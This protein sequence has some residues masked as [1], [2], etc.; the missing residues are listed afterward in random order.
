MKTIKIK[1]V[2]FYGAFNPEDNTITN[3]LRERYNVI[4]ADDPDYLFYSNFNKEYIKYDCVRIFYTGECLVPDFN[5]CD[6]A[7]A[8]EYLDFGDRYLRVPLYELFH[9]RNKYKKLLDNNVEK[10]NKTDFCGFVVSNDSGM[11]ERKQ[12]FEL[13]SAYKKV[14]SGGRYMNNI[15]GPVADKLAFDQ[16]HRFSLTFENC[17][18]E[19]YT[20][21]KIVE[22]FAAGVIPIY[23]GNPLIGREFNTKAFV[24]V[25][26]FS[27]LEDVVEYVKKID[28]DPKLYEQIKSEPI[29]TGAR[30]DLIDLRKFLF[31]I[32]DQPLESARRRPRNTYVDDVEAD[33]RL[34]RKYFN[35]VGLR[36]KRARGLLRRLKNGSL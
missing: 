14:D 34:A 17:C 2:G 4:I 21:E 12:M 13:L 33:Q 26:D 15:G 32:F 36:L 9:Y 18:H 20:T 23:Y 11:P 30:T 25:H 27:S 24:N 22:A 31:R 6:Y 7:M 29:I 5:L 3:I 19:G 10:T 35:L 1:F 8:F 28:N 16:K